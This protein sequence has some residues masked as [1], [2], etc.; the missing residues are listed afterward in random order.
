MF[1]RA[2]IGMLS[3]VLSSPFLLFLIIVCFADPFYHHAKKVPLNY[4]RLCTCSVQYQ[5]DTLLYRSEFVQ[6]T[7]PWRDWTGCVAQRQKSTI[8]F[9][10]R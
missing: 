8:G 4:E 1:L 3:K 10:Q 7:R 6:Q 9:E 2:K 5:L